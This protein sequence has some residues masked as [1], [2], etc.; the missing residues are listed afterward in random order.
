MVKPANH[1][2]IS[3]LVIFS[4]LLLLPTTGFAFHILQDLIVNYSDFS[5]VRSIAVGYDYVY[6]GT[7]GGLIR[8]H[9]AEGEWD[10]PLTG[11]DGL[12]GLD[13]YEVQVSSD[14]EYIWARTEFGIYEYRGISDYW[15]PVN[16]IPPSTNTISRHV[17][18]DP[19]YFPPEGYNYMSD[20]YLIDFE[21]RRFP[22]TDVVDDGWGNFWIGIWGLGAAKARTA[23]YH[24]ELIPY[25]LRQE[26][27]TT[28]FL[29]DGKLWLCG[30]PEDA[31]RPGLTEFDWRENRF[32][33]AELQT[34][35]VAVTN[36]VYDMYI[37][38]SDVFLATDY[39]VEIIDKNSR[40]VRDH[41]YRSSG[42]PDEV[43]YT[44]AV[45][46]D[47]VFVGTEYG[48]GLL[49]RY[50]DSVD[51]RVETYLPSLA[52][53]CLEQTDDALWIGTS[54]GVYRLDYETSKLGRLNVPEVSGMGDVYDI[55]QAG[56]RI[57]IAS[58]D[59][60]V[61][62]DLETAEVTEYP[63]V[64]GYG[65]ATAVAVADTLV[66]VA[67]AQGMLLVNIGQKPGRYLYTVNDGLLSEAISDLIFDGD[68]LW[69][70]SDRGLTR[71]WYKNPRLPQ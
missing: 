64:I 10:L 66:A 46:G 32:D 28:M 37:N 11:I 49:K 13:I 42:L 20:G 26:G 18:P 61:S 29:D 55:E 22:V 54:R 6:F 68:Y 2:S 5:N 16:E 62:I 60:L 48:L 67:V 39:G 19:L 40:T 50:R 52:V 23:N 41:F 24:L 36:Q 33:Y 15:L 4:V 7:T 63:E 53:Y 9:I 34:G 51:L 14:D 57:W 59:N 12:E 44:V 69:I 27:V 45:N 65:G 1:N 3:A 31:V 70:G 30:D 17:A 43:I 35:N 58:E 8:Y 56:D 21:G 47:T 71:F 25:G 38:G